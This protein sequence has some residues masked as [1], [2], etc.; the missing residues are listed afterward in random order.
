MKLVL[1]LRLFGALIYLA[2]Q[3]TKCEDYY[4]P[5]FQQWTEDLKF[6][7]FYNIFMAHINLLFHFLACFFTAWS[8]ILHSKTQRS[9]LQLFA[10]SLVEIHSNLA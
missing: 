3:Q 7:L 8:P 4:K 10:F 2:F 5:L 9:F 1:F 6:I